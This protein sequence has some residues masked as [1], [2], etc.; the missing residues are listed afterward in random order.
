MRKCLM[1]VTLAIIA[2][3]SI[4]LPVYALASN[5]ESQGQNVTSKIDFDRGPVF[6]AVMKTLTQGGPVKDDLVDRS[7][8]TYTKLD[9]YNDKFSRQ[10]RIGYIEKLVDSGVYHIASSGLLEFGPQQSGD[11]SSSVILQV[12]RKYATMRTAL[13]WDNFNYRG[14]ESYVDIPSSMPL[15]AGTDFNVY[16]HHLTEPNGYWIESGVGRVSWSSY[17]VLYTYTT[18]VGLWNDVDIPS[19]ISRAIRLFID[20]PSN[21]N[22]QMY[23]YDTYSGLSAYDEQ[24]VVNLNQRA[25]CGQEEASSTDTWTN[26]SAVTQR[27]NILKNSSGTWIYWNDA[28]STRFT[29]DTY[30]YQN[31]GI[32][33]NKRW[34][35]TWCSR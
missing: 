31:N 29:T 18:Y 23:A 1:A 8:I 35:S 28:V 15:S 26:T 11:S 2:L 27:D 16:M 21:G 13:L 5:D 4:L 12:V 22:A 19:G 14:H 32:W 17:P 9:G 20:I 34:I 30:M 25:D 6:Y 7:L 24:E 3:F 10:I 33:D